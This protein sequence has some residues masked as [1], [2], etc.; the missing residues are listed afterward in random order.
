[1]LICAG[2]SVGRI[3]REKN[4][5]NNGIPLRQRRVERWNC[6]LSNRA[7]DGIGDD[8]D[9]RLPAEW[10]VSV[11][12]GC[13]VSE[14]VRSITRSPGKK[15]RDERL[16]HEH[17]GSRAAAIPVGDVATSRSVIP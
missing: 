17:D 14:T 5:K 6:R 4:G 15:R 3:A 10:H 2:D 9:D 11:I 8:P 13:A 1:M 12:V 7:V 16:I